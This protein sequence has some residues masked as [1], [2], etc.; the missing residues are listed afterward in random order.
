MLIGKKYVSVAVFL[1]L[2]YIYFNCIRKIALPFSAV[3]VPILLMLVLC[4]V[5]FSSDGKIVARGTY[6]IIM[7]FAWLFIAIVA[8]VDNNS[9]A[10]NLV[11]GGMLQL[12]IMICFML[13]AVNSTDWIKPWIKMTGVFIM[14][15]TVATI[16]FFFFPQLYKAYAS[17]MFSGNARLACL[18]MYENGYMCGLSSHFSSNGM[19]LGIGVMLFFEEIQNLRRE[20]RNTGYKWLCFILT[21]YALI[22]SSKRSMFIA[23]FAALGITY[24]M[25][26]GKNIIKKVVIIIIA[27][28]LF[29]VLYKILET[30]IPGLDTL[31]KKFAE[32]EGSDNGVL[33][34]RFGLW[35]RAWEMFKTSP[36]IGHGLGSYSVYATETDAITTSAHNYYLQIAAEFGIVGL[37]LYAFAFAA[38]GLL[39]LRE[40]RKAFDG[41][42][43]K[44]SLLPLSLAFD[45]ILFVMLYC[46][47]STALMY[48]SIL[49]PF[50]IA[51]TIP[52][53]YRYSNKKKVAQ[54]I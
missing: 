47:T 13:F 29:V 14:I 41:K 31:V 33:N 7:C 32:L 24:L 46:M 19:I 43:G 26:N 40:M 6:D 23:A 35:M 39:A 37:V 22:L 16:L 30:K 10:S 9:L 18:R 44:D 53:A 50:F 4:I 8:F 25:S 36:I 21:V 34:G 17:L 42:Y 20:K 27:C 45:I 12:Y 2:Y 54:V 49:V 51:C 48:Y 11:N 5:L 3:T 28:V 15:H 52:R 38:G 1:L